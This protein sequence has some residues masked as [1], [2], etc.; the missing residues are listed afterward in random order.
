MSAQAVDY[1]SLL[2]QTAPRP[3][4]SHEDARHAR[5]MI[6]EIVTRE[7]PLSE[8]QEELVGLL[9]TLLVSWEE[10]DERGEI[11]AVSPLQLLNILMEDNGVRQAHLVRAGVFPNAAVASDV[12]NGKRAFTY[13][14]VQRLAAYFRVSPKVF[15]GQGPG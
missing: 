4:R 9:L 7:E 11:V 8:A 1:P 5:D 14:F 12:L 13:A 6:D 3:I 10:S 2:A 15:F